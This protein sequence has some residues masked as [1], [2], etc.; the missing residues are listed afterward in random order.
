MIEM[1]IL[2]NESLIFWKILKKNYLSMDI[3]IANEFLEIFQQIKSILSEDRLTV[4]DFK[5][6]YGKGE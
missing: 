5:K 2:D 3:Q 6:Y 4:P 1:D